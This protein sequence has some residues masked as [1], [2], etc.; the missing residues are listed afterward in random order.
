MGERR[1]PRQRPKKKKS[2]L[3]KVADD[4]VKQHELNEKRKNIPLDPDVLKIF[5]EE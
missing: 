3:D 1:R 2:H 4:L 5:E